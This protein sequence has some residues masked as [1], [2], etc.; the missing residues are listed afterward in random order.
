MEEP[1]DAPRPIFIVGMPRSGTT[2]V[3]HIISGHSSVKACGE[4][5]YAGQICRHILISAKPSVE[6]AQRIRTHYLNHVRKHY[7]PLKKS[8]TDKLPI[9]FRWIPAL[10]MTFP[11][12]KFI[13]VHRNPLQLVGLFTRRTS[14]S[15][16]WAGVTLWMTSTNIIVATMH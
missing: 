1:V 11:S 9:N 6:M 7:H 8:F 12:A 15:K 2:L 13:H 16:R 5:P 14:L 4:V 10:A 3:E